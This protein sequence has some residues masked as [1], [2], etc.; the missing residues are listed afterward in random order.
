MLYGPCLPVGGA[1]DALV[2]DHLNPVVVGIQDESDVVHTSVSQALL[3]GDID[4]V[5]PVAGRLEVI[6]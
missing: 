3:E 5:K 6:N 2:L 1:L 4:R